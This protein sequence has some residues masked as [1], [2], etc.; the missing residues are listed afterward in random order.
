MKNLTKKITSGL[1]SFTV[2]SSMLVGAFAVSPNSA[3]AECT[4]GSLPGS[5]QGY[6]LATN[7]KGP[8]YISSESWNQDLATPHHN[9]TDSP[10]DFYVNYDRNTNLWSGRGWHEELGWINFDH[11]IAGKKAIV[12][13][14][15][16]NPSKWG[17]WDGLIRLNRV[18]YSTQVGRF[19]GMGD[20]SDYTGGGG[21]KDI[22]VGMG[23]LD[24]SNVSFNPNSVCNESVSLFLNDTPTLYRSVCSDSF[25]P[26]IKWTSEN[27]ESN[28]QTAEGFWNN[29]A[30]PRLNENT[31]GEPASRGLDGGN[32]F[33]QKVFR[34]KCKGLQSGADVYGAAVMRCGPIPVCDPADTDCVDIP[35]IDELIKPTYTEV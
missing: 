20:G 12:E 28:C 2:A 18:Q 7:I 35:T 24:F 32:E 33:Q 9:Q 21:E 1:F 8:I 34:L 5:L 22:M 11:D 13:S 10:V 4:S 30:S 3:Q 31:A 6:I 25:V 23:D 16:S 29:P 17:N 26:R 27:V 19:V 14:V 15:A